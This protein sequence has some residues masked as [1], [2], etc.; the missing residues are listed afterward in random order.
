M[1]LNSLYFDANVEN[2]I[3]IIY[4]NSIPHFKGIGSCDLSTTLVATYI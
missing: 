3:I 1:T 4:V 2:T